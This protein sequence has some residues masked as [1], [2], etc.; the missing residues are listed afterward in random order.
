[1][2]RVTAGVRARGAAAA[3]CILPAAALAAVL[4][5]GC[6]RAAPPT[7]ES[8]QSTVE[9]GP[10]RLSAAV[11]PRQAWVGDAIT[12]ELRLHTPDEYVATLPDPNALGALRVIDASEAACRPAAEG[13]LLWSRRYRVESLLSGELEIPPLVARYARV[14]DGR[15][16]AALDQELATESLRVE[17]LSALTTQDSVAAPRDITGTIVPPRPPL[18]AWMVA[19]LALAAL[20]GLGVIGLGAWLVVRWLSRPPPPLTPEQWAL[21]ELGRLASAGLVAAGRPREHYYRMSEI[22]RTYIERRFGLAA[23]EMTTEEF[24]QSLS[25]RRAAL[26]FD[27]DSLAAY[28]A[29][30]DLVKY[31]ALAPAPA[32]AEQ[33]MQKAVAFI[34]GTAGTGLADV[35][36]GASGAAGGVALT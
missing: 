10:L 18:P 33:A 36:Q 19:A 29:A 34:R 4:L 7:P 35:G 32:D 27:R 6:S 8:L 15:A 26:P 21:Q 5:H 20:A 16:P 2:R 23:P 28:L 17:V 31:A 9:R 24:M 22:V 12:I 3:R 14:V 11:S 30:I 13:G 25:D 1:M